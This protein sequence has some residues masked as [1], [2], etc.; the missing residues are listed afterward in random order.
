MIDYVVYL[1]EA[2]EMLVLKADK[3]KD[4][5][6]KFP[7]EVFILLVETETDKVVGHPLEIKAYAIGTL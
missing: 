5:I 4:K 7:T 3:K 6:T 2:N 1:P